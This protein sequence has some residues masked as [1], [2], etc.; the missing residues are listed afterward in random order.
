MTTKADCILHL[1]R[2]EADALEMAAENG[3]GDGDMNDIFRACDP[4]LMAAFKRAFAKLRKCQRV[5][6]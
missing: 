6:A 3:Y 4:R 5:T 2:L 1:T